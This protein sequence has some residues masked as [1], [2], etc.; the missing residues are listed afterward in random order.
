MIEFAML[1]CTV[2]A[3]VCLGSAIVVKYKLDEHRKVLK[4]LVDDE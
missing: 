4:T 1:Y 3:M 2:M